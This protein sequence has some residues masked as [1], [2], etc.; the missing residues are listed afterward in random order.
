MTKELRERKSIAQLFV[1]AEAMLY[2]VQEIHLPLLQEK[3]IEVYKLCE[4]GLSV[5]DAIQKQLNILQN[6]K[7]DDSVVL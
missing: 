4:A 6:G 5:I 3:L 1:E 7:N 2:M